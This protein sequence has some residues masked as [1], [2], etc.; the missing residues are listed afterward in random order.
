MCLPSVL[1]GCRILP[2]KEFRTDKQA[3]D[4]IAGCIAREAEK[5]G[6]P[7]TEVERRMLYFSETD[8]T[9]PDMAEVSAEFDRDYDQKQYEQKIAG[10]VHK[11]TAH[12]HSNDLHEEEDWNRAVAR[13]SEGDRYILVLVNLGRPGGSGFLPTLEPAAIRPPH[14][15]LKLL[16]TALVV[17]FGLFGFFLFA[18][19]LRGTRF[20]PLAG[21]ILDRDKRGL[22]W[23]VIAVAVLASFFWKDLKDVVRGWL[24]S[25]K[26]FS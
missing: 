13:L 21:W 14:D 4:F 10:L 23:L 11:I 17:V 2:V 19:W 26:G 20:A 7:L 18:G 22:R 3:L 1:Y 9:L 12:H 16:V 5:E 25:R 15:I 6:V 24:D 8:W